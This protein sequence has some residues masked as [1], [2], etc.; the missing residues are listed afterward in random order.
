MGLIEL[1]ATEDEVCKDKAHKEYCDRTKYNGK[2]VMEGT[3]KFFHFL[4]LKTM[5]ERLIQAIN[6]A[7]LTTV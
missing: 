4:R 7:P 1:P 2:V 6:T 3:D 5:G